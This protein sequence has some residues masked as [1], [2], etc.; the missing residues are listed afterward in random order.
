MLR[1][2]ADHGPCLTAGCD[3]GKS[4]LH[5]SLHMCRGSVVQAIGYGAGMQI[6]SAYQP[7]KVSPI[8]CNS[9]YITVSREWT[10]VSGYLCIDKPSNL[11]YGSGAPRAPTCTCQHYTR[12]LSI[13]HFSASAYL[14]FF[15]S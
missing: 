11:P 3:A 15:T 10:S 7:R 4:I 12:A 6:Q 1:A 5:P 2:A 8:S 14:S 13:L 9:R